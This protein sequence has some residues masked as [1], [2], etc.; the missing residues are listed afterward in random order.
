M[1]WLWAVVRSKVGRIVVV[2]VAV[3]AGLG[4][5]RSRWESNAVERDRLDRERR[6]HD[7]IND[8]DIGVGATDGERR[9]RLH[10][11]GREW[12]GD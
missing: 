6:A 9:E 5:A 10:R 1:T 12:S 7:R 3:M 8:A 4:I 11:L 2:V